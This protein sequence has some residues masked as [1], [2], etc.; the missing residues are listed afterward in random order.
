[1]GPGM[2]R[3]GR[4]RHALDSTLRRIDCIYPGSRIVR[5][6]GAPVISGSQSLQSHKRTRTGPIK[7]VI[8]QLSPASGIHD[9]SEEPGPG[10][11][12]DR[13]T[14]A[15]KSVNSGPRSDSI[16]KQ[17]HTARNSPPCSSRRGTGRCRRRD[18]PRRSESRPMIAPSLSLSRQMLMQN[19]HQCDGSA[20]VPSQLAALRAAPGSP[21]AFRSRPARSRAC[22]TNASKHSCSC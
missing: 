2:D 22:Y 13:H 5:G 12:R 16:L 10:C 4:D 18:S 1:M 11:S 9:A 14:I 15:W 3:P 7:A 21:S 6:D 19:D 8:H 20:T 17:G